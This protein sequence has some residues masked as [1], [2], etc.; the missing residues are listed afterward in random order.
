MSVLDSDQNSV[1]CLEPRA[2]LVLAGRG[3]RAHTA[4]THTRTCRERI[5]I[6]LKS[7]PLHMKLRINFSF[8]KVLLYLRGSQ[9]S[10]E[11]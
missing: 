4:Q 7:N 3:Q 1:L 8:M 10:T 5:S 6:V 2:V 11:Q 9:N